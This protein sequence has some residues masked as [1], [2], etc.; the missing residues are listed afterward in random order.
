MQGCA[1]FCSSDLE[2]HETPVDDIVL[3][4]SL[5]DGSVAKLELEQEHLPTYIV[6]YTSN[7]SLLAETSQPVT[8]YL[9]DN[10]DQRVRLQDTAV[11][12]RFLTNFIF[13]FRILIIILVAYISVFGFLK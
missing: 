1:C 4:D 2:N 6:V 8:I 7:A 9:T 3:H 13:T 12:S 10:R 5:P 11:M